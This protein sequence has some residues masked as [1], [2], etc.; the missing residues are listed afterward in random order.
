[1]GRK[2][3]DRPQDKRGTAEKRPPK[4]PDVVLRR[5]FE[6]EVIFVGKPNVTARLPDYPDV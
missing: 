5:K 3:R 6:G 1:V 4:D 2:D